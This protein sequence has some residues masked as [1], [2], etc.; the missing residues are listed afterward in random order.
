MS[1]ENLYKIKIINC[2]DNVQISC[3]LKESI[4]QESI[5]I[6]FNQVYSMKLDCG[7]SDALKQGKSTKDLLETF[8]TILTGT[9]L[10]S[11]NQ[12]ESL[13]NLTTKKSINSAE[14]AIQIFFDMFDIIEVLQI[15][16]TTKS[17]NSLIEVEE[18]EELSNHS[19]RKIK[20]IN[21]QD[22]KLA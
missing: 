2:I 21:N 6:F 7:Y 9:G 20:V 14:Y 17:D 10:I 16:A 4:T 13:L 19:K 1:E 15:P 8:K 22:R 3:K 5:R 11:L 12:L 18:T